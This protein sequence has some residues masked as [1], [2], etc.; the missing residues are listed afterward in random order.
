MLWVL[1]HSSLLFAD[2]LK[3]RTPEEYRALILC[4][5]I[6]HEKYIGELL[7]YRFAKTYFEIA[8]PYRLFLNAAS[9]QAKKIVVS[10]G[11]IVII[12]AYIWEIRN[13]RRGRRGALTGLN[14]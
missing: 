5:L 4:S 11:L 12:N 10:S 7:N 14:L 8:K 3:V 9:P 6:R 13:V 1:T 2:T